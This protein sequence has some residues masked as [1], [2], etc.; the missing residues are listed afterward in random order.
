MG[1]QIK[2]IT[3]KDNILL[4]LHAFGDISI[5]A[6][7]L[8][9]GAKEELRFMKVF[10]YLLKRLLETCMSVQIYLTGSL[11]THG[12]YHFDESSNDIDL[13]IVGNRE[14]LE[15]IIR[16]LLTLAQKCDSLLLED[17]QLKVELNYALKSKK[18]MCFTFDERIILSSVNSDNRRFDLCF[19]RNEV[20]KKELNE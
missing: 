2:I 12:L 4:K 18:Y 14:A 11:I 6:G 19:V 7:S 16:P 15:G 9:V 10:N 17:E 8:F 1:K 13:L 5:P 3:P 20:F